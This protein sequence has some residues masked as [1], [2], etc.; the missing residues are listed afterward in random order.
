LKLVLDSKQLGE[1][2]LAFHRKPLNKIS[3]R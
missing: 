2:V 3:L 1:G